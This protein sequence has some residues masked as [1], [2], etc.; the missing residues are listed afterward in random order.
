MNRPRRE[1]RICLRSWGQSKVLRD[2]LRLMETRE[3]RIQSVREMVLAGVNAPV[4]HRTMED[5]FA[6]ATKDANV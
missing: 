6:A 4:S 3:Q 1:D 2:A 5:I